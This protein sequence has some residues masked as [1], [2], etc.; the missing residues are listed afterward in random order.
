MIRREFLSLGAS[1]AAAG[2]AGTEG[3]AAPLVESVP[4]P[5]AGILEIGGNK[6]LFLDERLIASRVRLS[7]LMGRPTK[8]G[9]I[10]EQDRPWE[11][12]QDPAGGFPAAGV[13]IS[14]QTVIYDED[15]KV[16]KMWYNPWSFFEG[17]AR[18]WCYAV[19]SD[20]YK[21]EKPRL[22]VYSYRGSRDNN[23]L[24]VFTRS[25]YFNVLKDPRDPDPKRR[26]KAMGEL[27]GKGD[28]GLAIAFSPDGFNWTE[29]P[30]NPV[31]PKG[32]DIADSPTMLGWDPRVERFVC[33]PRPG[34]PLA[35]RING[36]G[37]HVAPAK[38]NPNDG[39]MRTIGYSTSEDF[40]R[41]T[42]TR[43][44]LA[45]DEQDRVDFQYYQMTAAQHGEFYVG[46][47][48]MLQTHEQTFDIY[49]LTSR[50]GFHWN[51]VHRDLPFLRR[52][53]EGS[54]DAGYLTPSGPIVQGGNTWI[55]YGAYSGA[56]SAEKSKLG[57]NRMTIALATLPA[58]RYVGLLAG[59]DL[60]TLVTRPV[61]FCGRKLRIDLDA[62]L[63]GKASH[64]LTER[65]FDE[66][67]VRVG[68]LDEWGGKLDGF[69]VED[70]RML[71]ESGITEVSWGERDLAALQ[72]RP[73]R[74]RFEMRSAA[75]YSFQFV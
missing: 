75:L 70:C 5:P 47:M 29:Y 65:K 68:V 57:P 54:F 45:P 1:L 23:I 10:I 73:I 42:P 21:W 56:H 64:S 49:L 33:Y 19:S 48:H 55:Y 69:G 62:G 67:D 53:E 3:S 25:K 18:P 61:S 36:R 46:L 13:Q 30:G 34:P 4:T 24:G 63:P 28:N 15:E 20:G 9:P 7:R 22:G 44:M 71:T 11:G 40:V 52:G 39:Q 14:G 2:L 58:D 59:P 27:E 43:L 31:V 41:W 37:Y 35:T 17:R 32:R 16:F 38:V 66:A 6:Q 50:D 72:D 26:Y 12:E 60:A 8:K 74:L 51:W